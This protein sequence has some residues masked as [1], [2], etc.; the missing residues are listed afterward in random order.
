MDLDASGFAAVAQ[1]FV[2]HVTA[3]DDDA[4]ES[5]GGGEGGRGGGWGGGGG[6]G[7]SRPSVWPRRLSSSAVWRMLVSAPPWAPNRSWTKR[8]LMAKAARFGDR[9]VTTC[10]SV[11]GVGDDRKAR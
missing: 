7:G 3:P 6:G 1:Q 9:E 4:G 2:A 8:I 5:G 10:R 11:H